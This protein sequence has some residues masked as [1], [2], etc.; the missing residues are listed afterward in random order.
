MCYRSEEVA[1]SSSIDIAD[2]KE[3]D[4]RGVEVGRRLVAEV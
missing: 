2:S 1:R 4:V 3:A